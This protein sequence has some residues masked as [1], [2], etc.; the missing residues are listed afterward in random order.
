MTDR[1]I[2]ELAREKEESKKTF[3][4]KM[5]LL[6]T[7][8]LL[9]VF[10]VVA[11]IFAVKESNTEFYFFAFILWIVSIVVQL[12][13]RQIIEMFYFKHKAATLKEDMEYVGDRNRQQD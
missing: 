6:N 3:G 8:L 12:I 5:I 4:F 11:L 10:M 13:G 9:I 2:L 7:V 1:D